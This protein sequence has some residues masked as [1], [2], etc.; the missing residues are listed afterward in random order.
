MFIGDP[1][2]STRKKFST[3]SMMFTVQVK[4]LINTQLYFIFFYK[5]KAI[6][7]GL[8]CLS[9]VCKHNSINIAVFGLAWHLFLA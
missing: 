4:P 7:D 3:R 8:A 1:L 9:V 6:G 2:K 5:K